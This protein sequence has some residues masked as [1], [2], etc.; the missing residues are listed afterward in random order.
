MFH[1]RHRIVLAAGIAIAV[2]AA[3]SSPAG[4]RVSAAAQASTTAGVNVTGSLSWTWQYTP[5]S[6]AYFTYTGADK[7]TGTFRIDLTGED[8]NGYPT[9]DTS[10]Y[11]I[12]DND[13]I[14]S[15][16]NQT[17]CTS[18][19]T[20]SF[21][22]SGSFP[23]TPGS[24][25]PYLYAAVTPTNPNVD[26]IMGVPFTET[27]TETFGG[28]SAEG[29]SPG[30][31]TGTV[32][33]SAEPECL[34]STGGSDGDGGVLQG[35]YPDGTV[36]LSCSGTYNS[37]TDTGSFSITG[38]LTVGGG[39]CTGS[40]VCIAAVRYAPVA[41]HDPSTPGLPVIKDD[42]AAPETDHSYGAGIS[43]GPLGDPQDYDWLDCTGS[44]TTD[45]AWPVIYTANHVLDIDAVVLFST[46]QFP[47]P[48]LTATAMI[49][50][51]TLTLDSTDMTTSATATDGK[52]ELSA[53]SLAFTGQLPATAGV[54][55]LQIS[56]TVT[57]DGGSSPAGTSTTTAYVT[58]APYAQPGDGRGPVAPY[59]SLLDVGT[60][61]AAGQ[62]DPR[63]VF[64]AVWHEFTTL[65]ILHPQLNPQ[66][67][68][69]SAGPP[70]T[71]YTNGYTTIGSWWNVPIGT[72]PPLPQMLATNSG[73]CGDWA[74]VLAGV[75]AWQG[76]R[77]SDYPL[78]E[79]E[80]PFLGVGRFY[81]GPDV[82]SGNPPSA[83]PTC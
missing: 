12:T 16:N 28:P 27:Q 73:H 77:A 69:V 45:K 25:T 82:G 78:D 57:W 51:Q 47:D 61:A 19:T 18:G 20:G 75:L 81:P 79:A 83:T 1:R 67:G 56:W 34:T 41:D 37:G 46:V 21:S 68:Q 26:V 17:G 39:S 13:S 55:Q 8:A 2:I 31:S 58:A 6:N 63:A 40:I 70:L 53:A 15:T 71:Y 9:G 4:A 65:D 74:L 42:G 59:I 44:G 62:S 30:S 50:G 38:T 32:N 80:A 24:G 14:T 64:N 48:K 36:S 23:L 22:G 10:T 52:Y 3:M 76:I 7:Q 33:E 49:G 60:R 54:D 43:C 5:L 11:S 29:C 72:C 66:T 35:T